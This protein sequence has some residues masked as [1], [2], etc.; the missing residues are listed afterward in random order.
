[1]KKVVTRRCVATN[2]Q[3]EKKQLFRIVRTPD[4]NVILDL[5]GKANGRGAYISKSREALEIAQK[6]NSLGKALETTIP[7]NIYEELGKLINE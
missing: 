2:V 1:M 7:L 5:S 3:Y 6:K 4:G